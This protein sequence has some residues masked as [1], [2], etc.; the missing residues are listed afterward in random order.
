MGRQQ[1]QSG[2]PRPLLKDARRM[3]EREAQHASSRDVGQILLYAPACPGALSPCVCTCVC[4]EP[5]KGFSRPSSSSTLCFSHQLV[6]CRQVLN[7]RIPNGVHTKPQN[8][9]C[10]PGCPSFPRGCGWAVQRQRRT[11]VPAPPT[12][13]SPSSRRPRSSKTNCL[14]R[15]PKRSSGSSRP[16]SRPTPTCLSSRT[17]APERP[18]TTSWGTWSRCAPKSMIGTLS[19]R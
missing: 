7:F 15:G 9:V 2:V 3:G 17:T 18:S 14:T 12:T 8:T 6:P 4:F 10:Q 19:T 13:P 16:S 5:G 1:V 11:L